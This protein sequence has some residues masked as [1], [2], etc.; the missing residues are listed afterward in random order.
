MI[1]EPS[2]FVVPFI[3]TMVQVRYVPRSCVLSPF[4]A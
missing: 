3:K 1:K 4:F 2:L